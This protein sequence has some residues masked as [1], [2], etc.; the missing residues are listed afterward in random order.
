M[1]CSG[2]S[3]CSLYLWVNNKIRSEGKRPCS[4]VLLF[5]TGNFDGF[6]RFQKQI[7][8]NEWWLI[9]MFIYGQMFVTNSLQNSLFNTSFFN[10]VNQES[11]PPLQQLLSLFSPW[12]TKV[13]H[14]INYANILNTQ[15]AAVGPNKMACITFYLFYMHTFYDLC[16]I[17]GYL[18]FPPTFNFCKCNFMKNKAPGNS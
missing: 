3:P 5:I 13:H 18:I 7:V 10:F 6:F 16:Q 12:T 15:E 9:K 14:A 1:S 4:E 8:V 11:S 17:L 2:I